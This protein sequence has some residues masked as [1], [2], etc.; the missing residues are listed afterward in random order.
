[1]SLELISSKEL[2]PSIVIDAASTREPISKYIYGQF[3]EHLGRCIYGGLW[4]EMIG[5]RKF[6]YDF[7][8]ENSPWRVTGDTSVVSMVRE[9]SFV[10]EQ[11]PQI[12]LPGD[13]S[14]HGLKQGE[15][16]LIKDMG[17]EGRIIISGEPGAAPVEISLM[18]GDGEQDMETVLVENIGNE[19]KTVPLRFV[20]KKS[21]D[22]GSIEI[23]SRGRGSFRIGTVSLMP[24]NNIDGFR[25]DV[26]A[27]LKELDAPVY[28]W[29]GGNFV[30]GYDWKDGIGDRDRR[31]PRKNPA[32]QGIEPNDVGIHEFITLCRL[33]DTEPYVTVNTGL[34]GAES[35]A[36][37]VE[38]CNGSI[39]TPMGKLR[40]ENGHPEPFKVTWWAV[41]NEMYGSWQ[42]GNV[43][44]EQYVKKHN[45]V[46]EAMRTVD[47]DILLVAVGSVGRWDQAILAGCA[48]YMDYISEH[49]YCQERPGIIAHAVQAPG[50]VRRISQVMREYR[51]TIPALTGKDIRIAMD[52]WNYWY[53]PHV[54]G[55]LGT[56]YFLKDALG[57]A[58][59]LHEY[60]RNSDIVFMANYAQTVNVIGC[61]KTTKTEA[62]FATTGLVLKLYRNHF[63]T[64]PVDIGGTPEPLDVTAA[65]SDDRTKQTVAIVN[66][67]RERYNIPFELSGASLTGK[68]TRWLIT[69]D[70]MAYN[71]PG[72]K[73]VVT[74]QEKQVNNITGNFEVPPISI[75]LYVMPVKK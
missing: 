5:D 67:T 61:I 34:G 60:Y 50:Q 12:A 8:N 56:R 75:S 38:Y 46:V 18:W 27:L 57:I 13:G 58:E 35:A 64:V 21:T 3:I 24:E 32:W 29:P 52:E 65:W 31:P 62:A 16:G 44:V 19:Y 15:L 39:D 53:G 73:P 47:P 74:I 63:G 42:L 25:S 68:G 9:D 1:M 70:E 4:A 45:S 41:G 48:D 23:I 37:E 49:F 59:G 43:P 11:T 30:S 71:E 40:A 66:P 20:S 54:Y 6:Y 72:K 55:E 69:G 7:Q 51:S 33:I 36:Q 17:Y 22:S 26:L 2:N 10:G 14:A 28:R